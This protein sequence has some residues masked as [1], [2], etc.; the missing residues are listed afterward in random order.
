LVLVFR[1]HS[2]HYRDMTTDN[3]YAE[4]QSQILAAALPEISFTGWTQST[5]DAAAQAAGVD[6]D[7]ALLAFPDGVSPIRGMRQC[8]PRSAKPTA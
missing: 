6:A 8:S 5:L 3:P 7:M 1:G 2:G 4:A